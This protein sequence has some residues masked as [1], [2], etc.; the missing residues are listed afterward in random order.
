MEPTRP[1]WGWNVKYYCH[2]WNQRARICLVTKFDANN[3]IFKFG[4]KNALF[5]YFGARISNSYFHIWNQFPPICLIR[6]FCRKT[7][8]S[9]FGSKNAMFGY[10]CTKIKKKSFVAFEISTL[11]FVLLQNFSKKQKH[12]NMGYNLPYSGVLG[13]SFEKHL[14]YVKSPTSKLPCCKG[15]YKK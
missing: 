9:K 6:D 11:E 10:S 2:I 3:K 7:K 4:V 15:L 8:M 1:I 12:L 13:S 5:G 14:S